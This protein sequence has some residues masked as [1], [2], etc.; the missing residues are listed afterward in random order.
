MRGFAHWGFR[1][2]VLCLGY[3]SDLFKQYFLNLSMMV[4]DVTLNL[5]QGLQPTL[6][7]RGPE[8]EWI[9]TLADTG[10]DAMTGARVKRAGAFVPPDDDI[11]AVTY[12]DGVCDVDFR[13]VVDFHRAHSGSRR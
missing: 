13:K 12:G 7:Q 9:V 5:A 8:A 11:F 6:H 3:R 1:E 2:F 4:G 10:M